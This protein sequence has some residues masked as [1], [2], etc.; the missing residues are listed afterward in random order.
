MKPRRDGIDTPTLRAALVAVRVIADPPW[1]P[2]TAEVAALLRVNH[3]TAW[4]LMVQLSYL[5]GLY[6]EEDGARRWRRI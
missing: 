6:Q 1:E 5:F 2:T 4:R 3:S